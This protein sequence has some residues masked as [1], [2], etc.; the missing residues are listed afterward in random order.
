MKLTKL[1]IPSPISI[2]RGI[3]NTVTYGVL[4]G[5][6]K[7]IAIIAIVPVFAFYHWI[8]GWY[9][10]NYSPEKYREYSDTAR[11]HW[12]EGLVAVGV[13][14]LSSVIFLSLTITY[15]LLFGDEIRQLMIEG[16]MQ[17]LFFMVA[18]K[19]W[20]M[21]LALIFISIYCYH[22]GSLLF[23]K[24]PEAVPFKLRNRTKR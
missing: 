10:Q 1:L 6:L 18:S 15:F 11:G 16:K 3:A 21:Y 24:K 12:K 14:V 13:A 5:A 9:L 4:H 8:A 19:L 2:I 22:I 23:D 20:I 7:S 17:E